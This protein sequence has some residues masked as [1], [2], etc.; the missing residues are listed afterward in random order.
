[1]VKNM[2]KLHYIILPTLF[3]IS[4]IL[5][6]QATAG[7]NISISPTIIK[8]SPSNK[9]GIVALFNKGTEPANLQLDAKSWDMDEN[10]KFIE[11][12]TGDFIFYPKTLTIKPQQE[13]SVRVGYMG[14]FP[15]N[16]KPYRLLIEEIPTII[17]VDPEK[18]K[19]S[20]GVTTALR[21]SVPVYIVPTN[22]TPAPQVELGE[23]RA[24]NQKLRIGVK[25][26]TSYHVDLKKVS[27][28][29][30]KGTSTL[31][32]KSVDLKLQRVLGDHQ[33]FIDLPIDAKKLCAQADAI[34]VQFDVANLPTPYQ[35]QVPLK[36]GCQQ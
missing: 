1:M 34:A 3:I 36:A 33:V 5:S 25:N 12:D 16:E 2:S 21:F 14:D 6:T 18:D 35:T 8:L 29:L 22:E 4:T 9:T 13:A 24:D 19:V 7:A 32:E 17:Q 23:I 15:N 27:V 30:L 26:L 31:A 20:V 11:T 10:G 28:K